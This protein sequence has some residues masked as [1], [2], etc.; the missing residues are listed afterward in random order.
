[1]TG[2]GIVD[3]RYMQQISQLQKMLQTAVKLSM[4]GDFS[5]KNIESLCRQANSHVEKIVQADIIGLEQ[6][7]E[8]REN[9]RKLYEQLHLSIIAQ[10]HETEKQLNIVRKGKKIVR[11]Y[12]EILT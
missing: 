7:K 9:L 8:S 4:Q 6:F 11:K 2:Y 12:K 1:M 5:G 10:K 3:K